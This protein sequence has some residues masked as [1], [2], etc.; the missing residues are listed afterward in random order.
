MMHVSVVRQWM[1]VLLRLRDEKQCCWKVTEAEIGCCDP[2][3][4]SP[5]LEPLPS[6]PVRSKSSHKGAELSL[7]LGPPQRLGKG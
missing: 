3:S 4:S 7:M 5:S 6:N 2:V 1:I